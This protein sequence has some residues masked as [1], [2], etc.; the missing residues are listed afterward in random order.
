VLFTGYRPHHAASQHKSA[1]T[2]VQHRPALKS[3]GAVS[4]LGQLRNKGGGNAQFRYRLRRGGAACSGWRGRSESLPRTRQHGVRDGGRAALI[5]RDREVLMLVVE[6]GRRA[7]K[8]PARK[9][10]FV[11]RSHAPLTQSC[12][13]APLDISTLTRGHYGHCGMQLFCCGYRPTCRRV[14]RC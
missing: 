3:R 2:R 1:G 6:F 5:E 14:H 4:Y 9:V 8:Y 10:E 11:G 7:C 12:P 13:A